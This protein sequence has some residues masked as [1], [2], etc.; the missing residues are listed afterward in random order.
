MAEV[1][2]KDR[3]G[4]TDE[5]RRRKDLADVDE[6]KPERDPQLLPP[7]APHCGSDLHHFGDCETR[8]RRYRTHGRSPAP[9]HFLGPVLANLQTL[10]CDSR[11]SEGC[12]ED[13]EC[14]SPAEFPN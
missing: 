8:H 2:R 13:T 11:G 10:P 1:D 6:S 12:P 7:G 5:S 9:R 3:E 14:L 4:H